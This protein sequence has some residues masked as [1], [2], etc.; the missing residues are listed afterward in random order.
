MGG[1][2]GGGA[3]GRSG[4]G[5]GGTDPSGGKSG[6][7]I[8]APDETGCGCRIETSTSSSSGGPLAWLAALPLAGL[9]LRRR[10]R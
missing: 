8:V 5:G 6:T 10:R 3:G 9:L 7:G 2:S 1:M 4:S